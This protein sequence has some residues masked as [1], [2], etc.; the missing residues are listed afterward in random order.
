MNEINFIPDERVFENKNNAIDKI[1][2]YNKVTSFYYEFTNY[3]KEKYHDKSV[4][5]DIS[6]ENLIEKSNEDN[7][8]KA[9]IEN[10]DC[11]K[12]KFF[13]I[14]CGENLEVI[15]DEFLNTPSKVKTII[16]LK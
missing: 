11:D 7:L 1:Q 13:Q 4:Y 2:Y 15:N 5:L 3:L 8:L 16:Y 14:Y 12:E 9:M 10:K 6:I